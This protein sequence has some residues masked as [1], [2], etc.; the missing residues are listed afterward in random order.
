MEEDELVGNI[1]AIQEKIL[2]SESTCRGLE[3][4]LSHCKGALDVLE[5]LATEDKS[6]VQLDFEDT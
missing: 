2:E 4:T 1:E 3:E 6:V 5:E